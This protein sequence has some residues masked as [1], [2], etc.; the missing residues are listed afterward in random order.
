MSKE[1]LRELVGL[2]ESIDDLVKLRK[3]FEKEEIIMNRIVEFAK[4]EF[5]ENDISIQGQLTTATMLIYI[6]ADRSD[7]SAIE[8]IDFI[9]DSFEMWDEY[10]KYNKEYKKGSDIDESVHN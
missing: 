8:L 10:E 3:Q 5:D 1:R 9:K 2:L 7:K 4:K 6:V